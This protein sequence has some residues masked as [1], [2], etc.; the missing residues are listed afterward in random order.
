MEQRALSLSLMIVLAK[1]AYGNFKYWKSTNIALQV[2]L[3]NSCV[4][5]NTDVFSEDCRSMNR[6]QSSIWQRLLI[7]VTPQ[8]V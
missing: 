2:L 8:T 4:S 3:S 6:K 1:V 7:I 5:K